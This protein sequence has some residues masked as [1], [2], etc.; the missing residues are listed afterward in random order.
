MGNYV[1][2]YD[3]NTPVRISQDNYFRMSNRPDKVWFRLDNV[4]I[5]VNQTRIQSGAPDKYGFCAY[6][7]GSAIATFS[8]FAITKAING[9]YPIWANQYDIWKPKIT[10]ELER[11][12]YS[13]CFAFSL[14][15]NRC[16]VTKFEKDNPVKD[17]PEVFVDNPLCPTNSE[18][19]WSTTLE[20][21]VKETGSTLSL[22]LIDL[23]KDL[24]KLWNM[25]FC[26]SAFLYNAGLENETY[27]KYFDYE[28]FLTPYSGLIQIR[29]Y[30][31]INSKTDLLNLFDQVSDKAKN[32]K[33][34]IYDLLTTEFKYFD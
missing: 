10:K 23:V 27:F 18:S 25:K 3:D 15:E 12:F 6:D 30:A 1:G 32:V 33:N 13:L 8:W 9:R 2:F 20:P 24:Y 14:V 31:E 17:A 11:E 5:N 28:D 7:L 4:L 34:K 16:V 21:Y 19:F 26:K 22:Q 29:R